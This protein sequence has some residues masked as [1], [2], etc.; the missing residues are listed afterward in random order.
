[1]GDENERRGKAIVECKQQ[2][3]NPGGRA[4]VEIAGWLVGEQHRRSRA[5]RAGDRNALLFSAGQLAGKMA[6]TIAEAHFVEG[7]PRVCRCIFV[8]AQFEGQCDVLECGKIRQQV[9][10]L[11][12]EADVAVT[13]VRTFVFAGARQCFA[14]DQDRA[15]AWQIEPRE[16]GQ[17]C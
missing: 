10:L 3:R 5:V 17:Q 16:Q 12:N 1:M 11:E 2:I 15:A 4:L 14:V 6:Q 13:Q 8:G 7:V 9:K